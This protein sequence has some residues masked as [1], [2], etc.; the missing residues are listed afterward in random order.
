MA[1]QGINSPAVRAL[2]NDYVKV[3]FSWLL[4]LC[5]KRD[6]EYNLGTDGPRHETT[7]RRRG[8][9][10]PLLT[11]SLKV[12]FFGP[13][14]HISIISTVINLVFLL[15]RLILIVMFCTVHNIC[16]FH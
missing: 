6:D 7:C 10:R 12:G 16:V 9:G 2:D 13:E 5:I 14:L 8:G 3:T 4:G 15:K 11:K 1:Q